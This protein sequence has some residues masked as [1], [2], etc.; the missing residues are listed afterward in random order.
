MNVL[1]G[2]ERAIVTDTPGTTRDVLE[3]QINLDGITLN[4]AD[5]AGIRKTEDMIEK[6]G[7]D[8][9]KKY[10]EEADLI[11]YVVDSSVQLDENDFEIMKMIENRKSVVLFNKSDLNANISFEDLLIK[12]VMIL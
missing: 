11:V 5:T 1:I 10:I 9:A 3:E 12:P 8:K 4:I 7:V 2:R 6:I